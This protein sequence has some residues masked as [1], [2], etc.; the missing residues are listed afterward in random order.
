M[1]GTLVHVSTVD[2]DTSSLLLSIPVLT[3]PLSP[4]AS[5]YDKYSVGPS[6]R[7]ICT[8]CCFTMT[9]MI[10]SAMNDMECFTMTHMILWSRMQ[11]RDSRQMRRPQRSA[12]SPAVRGRPH[13]PL[14]RPAPGTFAVWHVIHRPGLFSH[15]VS[16]S[17]PN[18]WAGRASRLIVC[19]TFTIVGLD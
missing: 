7:P 6:I 12:P 3:K 18:S 13:P 2:R 15:G 10:W 8:R 19:I 14:H 4:T 11:P 5:V 16:D 1:I 17:M 9:N